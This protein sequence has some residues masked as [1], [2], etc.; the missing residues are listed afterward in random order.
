MSIKKA[1]AFPQF[2]PELLVSQLTVEHPR[3]TI[4]VTGKVLE[5]TPWPA[6]LPKKL[7]AVIGSLEGATQTLTACLPSACTIELGDVV[8]VIGNL[9]FQKSKQ[10]GFKL[11]IYGDIDGRETVS[12]TPKREKLRRKRVQ[13]SLVGFARVAGLEKA[14]ILAT[15]KGRTDFIKAVQTEA[16]F[17]VA[18]PAFETIENREKVL[19]C[20]H[21]WAN[22]NDCHVLP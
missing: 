11:T 18:L 3:G 17:A 2:S 12:F 5:V 10:N 13:T 15:D 6:I 1:Q 4:R 22:D 19:A 20:L 8:N 16:G 21:G 9:V 14:R 7:Y